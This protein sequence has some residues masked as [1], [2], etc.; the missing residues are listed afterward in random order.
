MTRSG[1]EA[2]STLWL[3]PAPSASEGR[4]Q[5]RRLPADARTVAAPWTTARR[6]VSMVPLV[7]K[8][9]FTSGQRYVRPRTRRDPRIPLV[10]HTTAM[11]TE[12][13]VSAGAGSCDDASAARAPGAREAAV[14]VFD[15]VA[16]VGNGDLHTGRDEGLD[17]IEEREQITIE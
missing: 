11:P 14:R 5:T 3:V 16:G 12:A 2:F 15:Q 9:R 1:T 8:Q 7:S 4:L 13:G 6:V 10:F 17:R